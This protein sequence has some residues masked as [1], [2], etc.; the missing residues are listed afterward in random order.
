MKR[1]RLLVWVLA[2]AAVVVVASAGTWVVIDSVGRDVLASA[3]PDRLPVAGSSDRPTDDPTSTRSPRSG[4]SSD[5]PRSSPSDRPEATDPPTGSSDPVV[6]S[7]QGEAGTVT[8]RCDGGAA[9]LVSAVPADGW[10]LEL[11]DQGPDEVGV[12]LESGDDRDLRS[13]VRARCRGG[14]PVFELDD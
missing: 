6:R 9:S 11:D 2:W 10:A 14:V 4:P 5:A 3:E 13:R 7:W 8:V 12:E 1:P